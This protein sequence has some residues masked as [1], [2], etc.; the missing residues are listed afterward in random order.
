MKRVISVLILIFVLQNISFSQDFNSAVGLRLGY[1]VSATYKTFISESSALEGFAGF[2]SFFGASFINLSAAYQI[3]KDLD[4]E[5]IENLQWYYGFGGNVYFWTF[6][7]GSSANSTTFGASGYLGLSYTFE[8]T[9]INVS[10][11]WVPTF[12]ING[13]E[14]YARNF[15]G[16]YGSLAVRYI[17][18]SKPKND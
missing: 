9:P 2:R 5:E 15:N 14:G 13:Q 3:H 18:N 1:P 10:A 8:N 16:G 11:D 6:D 7:F 4:F 17:F 12:F